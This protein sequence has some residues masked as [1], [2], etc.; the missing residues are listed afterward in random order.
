MA[1][2]A[3]AR[4]EPAA[5]AAVMRRWTPAQRRLAVA[6]QGLVRRVI[7]T[8]YERAYPGWNAVGFRDPQAGYVCGIFPVAHGLDLVFE[9][10]AALA[11]PEGL[12]A[13]RASLRQVRVVEV[14]DAEV[15]SRPALE[16]LLQQAVLHGSTRH[17]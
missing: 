3:P 7:P 11:D 17:R 13:P 6:C 1:R 15:L 5:V 2:R 4:D 9:H 16:T 14:D 10:G 12:F 8:M